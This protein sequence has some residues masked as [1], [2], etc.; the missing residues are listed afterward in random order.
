MVKRVIIFLLVTVGIFTT[1]EFINFKI[2]AANNWGVRD[3][4][5]AAKTDS[6]VR[7]TASTKT[8]NTH[9]HKGIKTPGASS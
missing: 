5:F 1:V 7:Q 9:Q 3:M 2:E 4:D 8:Y 6:P